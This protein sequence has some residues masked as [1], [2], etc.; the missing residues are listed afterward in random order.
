MGNEFDNK[1]VDG[2]YGRTRANDETGNGK[3]KF[4]PGDK[5]II[6]V[7]SSKIEHKIHWKV[8]PKHGRILCRKTLGKDE[9]CP[10]CDYLA[11][12]SAKDGWARWACSASVIDYTDGRL[13][14]WDFSVQTKDKIYDAMR[15]SGRITKENPIANFRIQVERIGESRDTVYKVTIGG[16]ATAIT[17]E[18]KV[19]IAGMKPIADSF[20]IASVKE[21][22]GFITGESEP[23]IRET[24]VDGGSE[25][26]EPADKKADV[27]PVVEE[28]KEEKKKEEQ[29]E[30]KKEA[31][32]KTEPLKDD[33]DLF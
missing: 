18:E 33:E 28:K 5:K 15:N 32:K 6:R 7:V 24:K 20:K 2:E 17:E 23:E 21:L 27:T 19:L 13:K 26:D 25:F 30:E 10:I 1:Y 3:L 9:E 11:K 29:K 14:Q 12:V 22:R 4:S 8:L 16:E 31:P